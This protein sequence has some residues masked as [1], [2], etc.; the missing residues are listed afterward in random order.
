MKKKS[1]LLNIGLLFLSIALLG[2]QKNNLSIQPPEL[3]NGLEQ[4]NQDIQQ[5]VKSEELKWER[6]IRPE[7]YE[8][9]FFID[10]NLL[11]VKGDN[12]K[13]SIINTKKE[14]ISTSLY[15]EISEF[16]DGISLIKINESYFF[17]DREGNR[18]SNEFYE[19]AYG[20]N[21]GLAA[22]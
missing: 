6:L 14:E 5:S 15:D 19:D 1:T 7:E 10:N 17:I 11:A 9:V 2:C 20:F 12:G 21:N 4:K 22:V 8:D 3:I 16:Q 18:L 13:Y